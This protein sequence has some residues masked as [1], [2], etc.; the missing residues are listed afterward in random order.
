M[1]CLK[2]NKT[3]FEAEKVIDFYRVDFLISKGK[4]V[5]EVNGPMHYAFAGNYCTHVNGRTRMKYKN[6]AAEGYSV[7][8]IHH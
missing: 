8:T 3:P 1:V 2:V 4:L 5:L 6:L 7:K